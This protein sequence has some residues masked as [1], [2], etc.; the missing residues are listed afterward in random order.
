MSHALMNKYPTLYDNFVFLRLQLIPQYLYPLLPDPPDPPEDPKMIDENMKSIH[1]GFAADYLQAED[2]DFTFFTQD[3]LPCG[4]SFATL[5]YFRTSLTDK[6]GYRISLRA[7]LNRI[8]GKQRWFVNGFVSDK[9]SAPVAEER[10]WRAFPAEGGEGDVVLLTERED[11]LVL[12][13][14]IPIP[15]YGFY[16]YGEEHAPAP[17]AAPQKP[18][19]SQAEAPVKE[20]DRPLLERYPDFEKLVFLDKG[21]IT[22]RLLPLIKDFSLTSEGAMDAINAHYREKGLDA[23]HFTRG[24]KDADP[25]TADALS[26]TTGFHTPDGKDVFLLCEP[27][28]RSWQGRDGQKR[29]PWF[30]KIFTISSFTGLGA[31]SL[32]KKLRIFDVHVDSLKHFSPTDMDMFSPLKERIAHIADCYDQRQEARFFRDCMEVADENAADQMIIPSG[33]HSESGEEIMLRCKRNSRVGSEPW[34]SRRFFL[35]SQNAFQGKKMNKWLTS[36]AGFQVKNPYDLTDALSALKDMA[37]AEP[38]SPQGASD[39]SILRSYLTY[40]F[41]RLW[42][43]GKV[44]EEKDYAAFNTGLVDHAYRYIYAL[45]GRTNPE[46]IGG[47]KWRFLTFCIDQDKHFGKELDHFDPLPRPAWYFDPNDPIYF[48]FNDLRSAEEQVPRYNADHILLERTERLPIPFLREFANLVDGLDAKLDELETQRDPVL[49]RALWS[50]VSRMI[51]GNSFAYRKI[52]SSFNDAVETAVRRAV[53]NY[54]TTVPYY[55]PSRDRIC[56]L[57]PLSLSGENDKPD[58]AMVLEPMQ[59]SGAPIRYRGHTIITLAMAYNNSRL[60]CRPE[61]AWLST[62]VIQGDVDGFDEDDEDTAAF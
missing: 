22:E 3:N 33:Y 61:S 6:N 17:E 23:C 7:T 16:P 49:R 15:S 19:A 26:F 59:V 30:G 50:D 45:F 51:Q 55:D 62:D 24:G 52:Y 35:P 47:R 27:N 1:R 56:L 32:L 10:S 40:T 4:E 48:C 46:S 29:E 60:V 34:V 18:P 39:L 21:K 5:M 25:D 11:D 36:W 12:S 8:P 20:D 37:M 43:E 57:L 41:V 31:K 2:D 14:V 58:L 9:T 42:R 13:G 28:I 54:R 53:W 44:M 38:W